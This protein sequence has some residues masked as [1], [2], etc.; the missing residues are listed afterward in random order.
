MMI[1]IVDIAIFL[2]GCC[3][4]SVFARGRWSNDNLSARIHSG[5]I[6][7]P[8]TNLPPLGEPP[9]RS[10]DADN[11]SGSSEWIGDN[12]FICGVYAGFRMREDREGLAELDRRNLIAERRVERSRQIELN[13]RVIVDIGEEE[14]TE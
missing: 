9:P 4:G 11:R 12:L 8:S 13:R 2:A 5:G 14:G 3:A 1:E 10:K 7:V 6:K